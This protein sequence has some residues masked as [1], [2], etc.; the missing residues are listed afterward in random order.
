VTGG[1]WST[2]LTARGDGTASYTAVATDSGGRAS[3]PSE[4]LSVTV[5]T[6]APAVTI[7]PNK[8]PARTTRDPQFVFTLSE[9]AA[10]ECSMTGAT[11]IATCTS[12]VSFAGLGDG[13]KTFTA[14]ATDAAGNVGSASYSYVLDA[15]APTVQ[16]PTVSLVSGSTVSATA[17]PVRV[18]WS[19]GD[20]TG[21]GIA[22]Y[23]LRRT[24]NGVAGAAQ[25]LTAATT[26]QSLSLKPGSTYVFEVRAV[27]NAGNASAWV[28]R[29]T[30]SMKGD[31]Q[32]ANGAVTYTGTW[33]GPTVQTGSYAGDVHHASTSGRIVRYTFT[34][35]SVAWVSTL[36]N[37]RGRADVF[38]DG[39]RVAAGVELFA[40]NTAAG[41]VVYANNAV[42]NPERTHTLE[43]RVLGTKLGKSKGTRVDADAFLSTPVQAPTATP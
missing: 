43:I 21:S 8:L 20:G 7:D 13:A 28:N 25:T 33:T 42:T 17:V 24:E 36:A 19:G 41:R 15:T 6:R 37:N 14:R 5:D 38:L 29:G 3:A 11:T 39:V 9:D 34:G 40:D 4:A 35:S 10:V 2:T 31:D 30:Y 12:P 27:D 23:E 16:A 22:R 1:S 18:T 26:S 32:K